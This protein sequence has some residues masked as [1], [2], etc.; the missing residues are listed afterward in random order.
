[1][2][3]CE[4]WRSSSPGSPTQPA[5]PRTDSPRPG[6]PPRPLAPLR[7][8]SNLEGYWPPVP[9]VRP[10]PHLLATASRTTECRLESDPEPPSAFATVPSLAQ[11]ATGGYAPNSP[12]RALLRPDAG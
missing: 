9:A 10:P 5:W 3:G 12:A 1:A 7:T 2:R 4:S 6:W 8:G 11:A